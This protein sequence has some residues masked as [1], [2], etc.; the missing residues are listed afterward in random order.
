MDEGEN[1]RRSFLTVFKASGRLGGPVGWKGSVAFL[2][3]LLVWDEC[4]PL[5]ALDPSRG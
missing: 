1:T 2:P 5:C 4:V 3:L